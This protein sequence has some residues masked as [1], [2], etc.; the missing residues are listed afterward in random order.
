MDTHLTLEILMKIIILGGAGEMG[1]RTAEDLA[2]A[3]GVSGITIA[4][5]NEAVA[6]QVADSLNGK[7]APVD[8]KIVDAFDQAALVEALLGYDVAVSALGPFYIFEPKLI[9]AA[10]EASVN[11][12][13]ICDEWEPAETVIEQFNEI[14]QE[15][16]LT[17]ITGLGASPGITNMGLQHMAQELDSVSRVR[18]A[19]YLPLDCGAQGAALRHGLYIMTGQMAVWRDGRR[20]MIQACSEKCTIDFPQFGNI[21][22]WNMGH[23]EPVTIPKYFP[24]VRDVDFYMGY[25]FGT[26]AIAQLGRWGG[27]AGKRR[28]EFWARAV[29]ISE[30]IFT[31][32]KA[33]GGASRIDAWGQKDGKEVHLQRGGIGLMRETTGLSLAA[34]A[35]LLGKGQLRTQQGG[36]YAPEGCLDADAFFKYLHDRGIDAFT[37][38]AMTQPVCS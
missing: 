2:A 14:A 27:F 33:R 1:S 34:G 36:V 7:G 29:E 26:G 3:E 35:Y 30:Q 32:G 21:D 24:G 6:R 16:G 10:I 19:I 17:I 28:A 18:L 9:K 20:Q 13:S 8:V 4:D 15:K 25:G 37:D 22:C 23:S 31:S 38:L 11:Y 5:R 12:C